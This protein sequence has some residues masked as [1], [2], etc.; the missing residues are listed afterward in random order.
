MDGAADVEAD[1]A[2]DGPL[3][4]ELGAQCSMD[5]DCHSG[6]C[7]PPPV[8]RCSAP[9]SGRMDCPVGNNWSCTGLPGRGNICDC[10][11]HAATEI[12]CNSIDDDCDGLTDQNSGFC[13]G[14]CVDLWASNTNCGHCGITC[15]GGSVCQHGACGCPPDRP[16]VCSTS[17][18][19]LASDVAHCGSCTR[20]CAT[21]ANSTSMCAGGMCAMTCNPGFGDCNAASGDGCETDLRTDASNCGLCGTACS[22]P[23]AAPLCS[24]G[25][26][27]MGACDAG[28]ADC[29]GSA[30]DGCE[31]ALST[32]AL[33]CGAC[34]HLCT[35]PNA[36]SVCIAGAC[37]LLACSAGFGN[38]DVSTGNG[39]EVSLQTDPSNCGVCGGACPVRAHASNACATGA[40][41]FTCASGY[42]D[43][44]GAATT[45]CETSL[46]T[47]ASHCG[48]CGTTCSS[49]PNA[50]ASCASGV[51]EA[52]CSPGFGNCDGIPSNGC[53]TDVRTLANC[54]ACGAVCSRANA[55]PQCV[56]GT[57]STQSCATFFADCDGVDANGCEA[58]VLND[59]SHCGACGTICPGLG[60]ANTTA[61]C[62][63]GLCGLSCASG[64]A[65]CDGFL[66]NGCETDVRTNTNCGTCGNAC[67][68]TQTCNGGSCGCPAGQMVCAG[69][70]CIDTTGDANNCGTCGHVCSGTTPYCFSG[71]CTT[72]PAGSMT[73]TTP[74]AATFVV[75]P[76]V[77][78]VSVVVVGAGGAGPT[79]AASFGGGGGGALC[80]LNSITVTPGSS[81]PVV[82][83]TGG[84]GG[85]NGSQ[86]S[87]NG[88]IIAN[89]GAGTT[90]A[91][92][93]LG[94]TGTG[95]ACFA[96]GAGGS[97]VGTGSQYHAGGGGAAGYNGNGG[98]GSD[99]SGSGCPANAT[100]GTG[101][102]GGGGGG[103]SDPANC[104]AGSGGGG[105]GVGL[106]GLAGDGAGASS[107][108]V[109]GGWG[110]PGG[111]GSGGAPGSG[112]GGPS[113]VGGGAGG[114]YGGGGGSASGANGAVRVIWGAGR[115]FPSSAL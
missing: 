92:G 99:A 66:P 60:A 9:C 76:G 72:L 68:A 25:T 91:V 109:C 38:C 51:C 33:N 62:N 35:A 16:D 105:G 86:S 18:V 77:T 31:T 107:S 81:I 56:S 71:A 115:S 13:D 2:S 7:L 93:G 11:P 96:G 75:P 24:T 21:Q 32:D 30:L 27:A 4:G 14:M 83:G 55:I 82:V 10:T 58:N 34:G 53:E 47:D 108:C 97:F 95:G 46:L 67:P 102:G 111:G 100:A 37:S 104:G 43:C 113:G 6:I 63:S 5:S 84:V 29:N 90:T 23:H 42:A 78:S 110:Y 3:A 103:G 19:S 39:C 87:F 80:Y 20:A 74:G 85:S 40:C 15:G 94:G 112:T 28:F 101:G 45:G 54:G 106:N 73:F 98:R 61:T 88:T 89:G 69:T 17:C 49:A 26:C 59:P 70:T 65:N 44:D 50:I 1:V 22:F 57:C 12:G 36:T 41:G 8:G 114:N 48:S 64:F 79:G 52:T